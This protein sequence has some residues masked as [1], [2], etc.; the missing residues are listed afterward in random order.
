LIETRYLDELIQ[1]ASG[2][3]ITTSASAN[4]SIR[5]AFSREWWIKT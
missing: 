2:A 1:N 3:P 5:E 4:T